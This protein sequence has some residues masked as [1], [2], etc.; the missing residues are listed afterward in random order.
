MPVKGV[1]AKRHAQAVFQI[2]LESGEIEKWRSELK[3]IATTLSDPQLRAI[4]ESPKVHFEG[5]MALINQ[6]LPGTEQLALNLIYLLVSR[7][8]LRLIDQI[9]SE[10]ERLVN[11]YQGVEHAEVITAIPLEEEDKK[12]ISEHLAQ[13]TGNQIVLSTEVDPEL[14]G[15]FVARIGDRVIDGSTRNKLDCLRKSLIEVR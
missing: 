12:R 13:I 11:A 7:G 15:G 3:A 8:R 14:I 4:L 10:Y 6:C 1:A 2:A 9:L 5:K